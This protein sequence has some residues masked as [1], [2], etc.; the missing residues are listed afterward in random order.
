MFIKNYFRIYLVILIVG[1]AFTISCDALTD[2]DVGNN[3]L[4]TATIEPAPKTYGSIE[5][6]QDGQLISINHCSF[7]NWDADDY[8]VSS[9]VDE[10]L[11]QDEHYALQ[12]VVLIGNRRVGDHNRSL[13]GTGGPC[14]YIYV[15][16]QRI[17]GDYWEFLQ[18]RGSTDFGGVSTIHVSISNPWIV[19]GT[20][21]GTVCNDENIS[22]CMTIENG[23]FVAS[24][25]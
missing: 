24:W 1:V 5:F 17:E 14:E 8:D 12:I 22:D 10:M 7:G 15:Q 13:C 25:R 11:F 9:Y 19:E 4:L 16:Y 6:Y 23:S 20:F 18:Y 2:Q 21:S 3:D